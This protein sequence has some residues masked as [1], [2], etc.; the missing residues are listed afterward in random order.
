[1][2]DHPPIGTSILV[3]E[4][5]AVIRDALRGILADDHHAICVG[6]LASARRLLET[7]AWDAL[8]LDLVLDGERG[9][10]LL[11]EFATARIRPVPVVV[12]SASADAR[13]VATRYGVPVVSKPF[14]VVD[15]LAT[16]RLAIDTNATPR[17][18]R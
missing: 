17:D 7:G 9:E 18:P 1:V 16:V 13:A 8:L 11:E 4:D 5:D 14:G 2:E 3:V 15:L 12:V 10:E 6:T